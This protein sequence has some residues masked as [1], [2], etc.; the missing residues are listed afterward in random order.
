MALENI[1]REFKGLPYQVHKPEGAFFLW[2]WFP[3]L[4]ITSRQLYRRL[5]DRGVLIVPGEYFFPGLEEPWRHRQ[6]CIRLSYAADPDK[7]KQGIEIIGE[8]LRNAW[9]LA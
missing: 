9:K 5:K 1:H 3:D 7:V 2:L 4:P 6:E 8:E